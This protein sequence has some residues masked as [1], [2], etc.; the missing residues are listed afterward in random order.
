M[1]DFHTHILPGIDDGSAD[2]TVSVKM[3]K[4]LKSQGIDRVVATPHFYMTK[5]S[6][7]EF[8]KHR[9]NAAGLVA[10]AVRKET[11]MPKIV[12]GAE[13]LLYP[14]I[15]NMDGLSKLCIMGTRYMLVEMPFVEWSNITY[16]TLD[17]ICSMG[18]IPIIAHFERYINLHGDTGF[19]YELLDMGCLIQTNA[20]YINSVKT[21]RKA[22]R[23]IDEGQ[24]HIVG[25]DCHNLEERSPNIGKAYDK[26][27]RR[28]GRREIRKIR[29]ISDM[30]L[31]NAE[32]FV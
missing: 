18:I 10:D 12:L 9:E 24:I 5:E 26:I 28:L 20:G 16:T 6:V 32:Y 31:E 23:Y 3:L 21:G 13:V 11:D 4:K 7:E 1:V 14:E 30:V 17:K 25:S 8:L 22:L 2:T 15:S 27:A 29:N 19:L